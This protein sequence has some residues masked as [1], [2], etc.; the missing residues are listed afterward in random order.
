MPII[1]NILPNIYWLYNNPNNPQSTNDYNI[2]M[3]K[4]GESIGVKT[5]IELDTELAFWLKSSTYIQ[6]IKTQME[7]DEFNKLLIILKKL[8]E[9]IKTSY[10]SNEPCIISTLCLTK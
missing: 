4:Y 7:I 3:S 8:D 10:T 5:C 2:E 6:D 9:H 1:I